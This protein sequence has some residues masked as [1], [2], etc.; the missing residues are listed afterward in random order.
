MKQYETQSLV[1]DVCAQ[2]CEIRP[3]EP[4]GWAQGCS[5][6]SVGRAGLAQLWAGVCPQQ[7]LTKRASSLKAAAS[8]R[9]ENIFPLGSF[10]WE[11]REEGC[12]WCSPQRGNLSLGVSWPGNTLCFPRASLGTMCV[13]YLSPVPSTGQSKAPSSVVGLI[14]FA[15]LSRLSLLPCVSFS[16]NLQRS[17]RG[18]TCQWLLSLPCF[19]W[20]VQQ[21]G[22]LIP[23]D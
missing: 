4:L 15:C 3:W 20:T 9:G 14:D 10:W 7:R 19:P 11:G 13:R 6:G 2:V 22:C 21:P 5:G 16:Q 18:A 1:L 23:M 8:S 12:A 17:W